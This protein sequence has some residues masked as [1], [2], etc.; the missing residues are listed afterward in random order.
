[1]SPTDTDGLL[2][3]AG[4]PRPK[5]DLV[6]RLRIRAT[7]D[8]AH[9]WDGD[10]RDRDEA[11][12]EILRLREC[13]AALRAENAQLKDKEM[14]ALARCGQLLLTAEAERDLLLDEIEALNLPV[15]FGPQNGKTW[16]EAVQE[17]IDALRA[18]AERLRARIADLEHWQDSAMAVIEAAKVRAVN[19]DELGRAF[20]AA[21]AKLEGDK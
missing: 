13:V 18:D 8:I 15:P 21:L 4:G 12:T 16:H 20:D 17:S 7:A 11:A 19:Y 6:E 10:A 2:R 3:A 9:G 14:G 5:D 1:M